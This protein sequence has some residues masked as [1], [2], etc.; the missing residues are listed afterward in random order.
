MIEIQDSQ[1]IF[2]KPVM[3]PYGIMRFLTYE[4]YMD[5]IQAL[6]VISQNVLHLFYIFRKSIPIHR[7]QELKEFDS[8]KD[9]DLNDIVYEHQDLR[10]AYM[11]ILVLMLD[12]N[13]YI[14]TSDDLLLVLQD[15][16]ENKEAFMV[17]RDLIMKMNLLKE[18][19]V[20]PQA[21]L[22]QI[23]ENDKKLRAAKDKDAPTHMDIIASI[24]NVG[25]SFEELAK[26]TPFQIHMRFA[27]IAAKEDYRRNVL[28]AT[29]SNEVTIES[30]AKKT[31]L[32]EVKDTSAISKAEFDQKYAGM[33]Q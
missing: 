31:N 22:Q 28:F 18:E 14:Q 21:R 10:A 32:F 4:E 33:F 2:A 9:R 19:K 11:Q 20:S 12:Q 24:A 6:S 26:E 3:T 25:I 30:W 27:K 16:F 8:F 23:F 5:N 13:E 17:M 15:I 29:V 1:Y 7:K